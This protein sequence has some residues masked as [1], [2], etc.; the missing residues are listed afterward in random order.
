MYD[1]D[2]A[3]RIVQLIIK[4]DTMM[5]MQTNATKAIIRQNRESLISKLPPRRVWL[6]VKTL[7][8][9]NKRDPTTMQLR[10]GQKFITDG[11]EDAFAN[12][13]SPYIP[14]LVL[15]DIVA[16]NVFTPE[17]L[18]RIMQKAANLEIFLSS[19]PN[20][21][22]VQ[23]RKLTQEDAERLFQEKAIVFDKPGEAIDGNEDRLQLI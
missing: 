14:N 20:F 10:A 11:V 15:A 12:G 2:Q 18:S 21:G 3:R 6:F 1:L 8:D 22:L 9:L 23:G 19:R 4:S 7:R 16:H 13:G 5:R 17:S